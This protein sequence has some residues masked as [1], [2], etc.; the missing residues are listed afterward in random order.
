MFPD[1]WFPKFRR[2]GLSASSGFR[3]SAVG[4]VPGNVR[5]VVVVKHIAGQSETRKGQRRWDPGLHPHDTG[6]GQQN[7]MTTYFHSQYVMSF[8][9]TV[10]NCP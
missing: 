4:K 1:K 5:E 10:P 9:I 2:K 8:L 3:L 7:A 6:G